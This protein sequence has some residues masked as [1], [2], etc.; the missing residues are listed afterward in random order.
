M[1]SGE[2]GSVR[3]Q[4][5]CKFLNFITSIA[6]EESK[7]GQFWHSLAELG[8]PDLKARLNIY[9]STHGFDR[10]VLLED[11]VGTGNQM[12]RAVEFAATLPTTCPILVCPMV[13]CP[14]GIEKAREL[15]ARFPHISVAPAFAFLN[16]LFFQ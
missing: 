9:M 13:I 2:P 8:D 7:Y 14:K 3:L 6:L 12:A 1:R 5:A 16:L 11:F 10:L 15:M 4:T